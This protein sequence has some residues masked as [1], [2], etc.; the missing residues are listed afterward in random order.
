MRQ[1][2]QTLRHMKDYIAAQA[3]LMLVICNDYLDDES[4]LTEGEIKEKV[5]DL[6]DMIQ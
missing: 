1:L 4:A 5:Y 6:I 2:S 3:A